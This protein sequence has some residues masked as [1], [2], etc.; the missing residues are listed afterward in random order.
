MQESFGDVWQ[1]IFVLG[2]VANE[3]VEQANEDIVFRRSFRITNVRRV[4]KVSCVSV[5][6]LPRRTILRF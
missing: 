6:L 2:M 5:R 4:L 1:L 3:V